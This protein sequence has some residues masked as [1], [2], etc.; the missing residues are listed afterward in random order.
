MINS[1]RLAHSCLNTTLALMITCVALVTAGLCVSG[2]ASTEYYGESYPETSKVDLFWDQNDVRTQYTV[3][4]RAIT[5]EGFGDS[6]EMIQSIREEAMKRG[7]H[8]VIITKLDSVVTGESE[9]GKADDNYRHTNI[10]R[11]Q[12]IESKFIRYTN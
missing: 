8:G 12:Q 5:T 3:I 1:Q 9:T 10:T 2:C 6:E 4:G 7:A 11:E